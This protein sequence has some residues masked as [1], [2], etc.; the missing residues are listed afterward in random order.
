MTGTFFQNNLLPFKNNKHL[1]LLCLLGGFLYCLGVTLGTTWEQNAFTVAFILFLTVLF[2]LNFRLIYKDSQFSASSI[3]AQLILLNLSIGIA[4]IILKSPN[5]FFWVDDSL[6]THLNESLKFT[7]FFQGNPPDASMGIYSGLSTHS[8]TGLLF[9]IFGVNVLATV[10]AQLFFKVLAAAFIY[11]AAHFLWDKKTALLAMLL[12]GL[13]PTIFFYNLVFYKE[14]AVQAFYAALI[15]FTLKI[16]VDKKY[17]YL[18][19]FLVFF[20]ALLRERFYISYVFLVTVALV[21]FQ[22]PLKKHPKQNILMLLSGLTA[23]FFVYRHQS[24]QIQT[25]PETLVHYRSL[26]TNFGDVMNQYNYDIPYPVAFIKILFSPYFSPNKFKIFKDFST[27][28]TWGSF[29]NQAIILASVLGF[30]KLAR[31]KFLHF[32]LWVPFILFLLFTAYISPWSG[33]LRDSFYPLI[34]CYA[35]YFICHNKFIKKALKLDELEAK[36]G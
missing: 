32:S 7:H 29:V 26:H 23:V 8:F 25:L 19:P 18:V 12:Y 14:S 28:L 24:I 35:A 30:I 15:Y 2:F 11:K 17:L 6:K 13:C 4:A 5:T 33:R 27:L 20:A 10:I 21:A 31:T 34:S 36:K 9:T 1:Y 22:F 3:I 16:F